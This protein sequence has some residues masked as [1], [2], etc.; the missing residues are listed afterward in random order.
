MYAKMVEVGR[1]MYEMEVWRTPQ[2]ENNGRSLCPLAAISG[3]LI[4]G[5][6]YL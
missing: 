5:Q 2:M 3:G 1:K 4:L 6:A